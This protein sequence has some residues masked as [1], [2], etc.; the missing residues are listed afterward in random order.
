MTTLTLPRAGLPTAGPRGR[1]HVRAVVL[2][3]VLV[4]TLAALAAVHLTQGTAAVDASDLL[5]LLLGQ[6]TDASAL[7]VIDSRWPRLA[8]ALSVGVA[9]GAGGCVLQG[10]ARNPL[11]SPD[12]LAVEAGAHLALVV[13]ALLPFTLPLLGGV[14]VA[15][16]GGV[17]A[18]GLL[19]GLTRG[20]GSPLRLVLAG[21]V[22]ALAMS[23]LTSALMI[24]HTQETR[25]LF[26][27]GAGSLN[28]RGLDGIVQVLPAIVAGVVVA[29]LLSRNLDLLAL[30]EDVARGLGVRVGASRLALAAT[31]VLLTAASV[32]IAGP[33]GFVG[34]CA[35]ALAGLAA[36]AVPPLPRHVWRIPVSALTGVLIVLAADV[37]LRLLFGPL[38]G[39][40][41]PTGVVTTVFGGVFL[42]VAAHRLSLGGPTP[43]EAVR[44]GLAWGRRHPAVLICGVAALVAGAGATALLLGDSTLLFGDVGNW[45][46]GQASRRVTFILDARAPR[47][48]SALL[49]GAALALAGALVQGVTRNALADPGILG[50]SAG[51]G[52]G[53]VLTL[54]VV[55]SASWL[56][57]SGGAAAGAF[58]A[59]VVLFA[60]TMRGG[61][62]ETR[63]V[64][65]GIGLAAAAGAITS[66]VLVRSDPWNQ[67][68]AITWLGGSTY[69][70]EW[71]HLVP[72]LV[73]L[74]IAVVVLRAT[75]ADL[76]LLQVDEA[77]PH[78]L[79]VRPARARLVALGLAVLLTAAAT[80]S[81]GVLAFVGLVG[82]HA[83]RLFVGRRHRWLLPLSALLGGLLVVVADTVGRTVLAPNQ[84][85]AGL[86]TALV[87]APYFLWLLSRVRTR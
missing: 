18:A 11:A 73:V 35:P 82:P 87:G 77:T 25:G 86:V 83:A 40:E 55:P 16:V 15:F 12:T 54:L 33:I 30:G 75:H 78:L 24:L 23:S 4:A 66:A 63:V 59:A 6:G 14:G 48:A 19:L 51:A 7:V 38:D 81:I 36:R 61:L 8:A 3:V 79:G 58:A 37:G 41:V 64:L 50:V 47:V 57:V 10:L 29:L 17:A 76:D 13:A 2:V 70:A 26:A 27:W 69:G 5:R 65:V 56:A 31:A 85:P 71:E 49:A 28:Q 1:G 20:A 42:A 67:A 9:L 62:H 53:A 68:K 39:V 46:S 44:I 34:L 52:L 72:L 22:L 32:T 43:E 74:V 60:L 84:L 80:A 45:L 21:T